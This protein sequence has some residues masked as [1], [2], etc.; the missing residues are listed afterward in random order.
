[1]D[2]NL[3]MQDLFTIISALKNSIVYALENN[4]TDDC[5]VYLNLC[6]RLENETGIKDFEN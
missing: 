6:R 2:I 1:M 5:I 4:E 3:N